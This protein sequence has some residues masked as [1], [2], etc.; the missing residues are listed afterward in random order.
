M[1]LYLGLEQNM[2]VEHLNAEL[3]LNGTIYLML[4]NNMKTLTLL[5]GS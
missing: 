2:V 5:K 3:P 1:L 4:L